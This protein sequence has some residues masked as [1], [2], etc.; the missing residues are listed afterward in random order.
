MTPNHR[1]SHSHRDRY[2]RTLAEAFGPYA[3]G[4]IHA[5]EQS[6]AH[7]WLQLG[8]GVLVAAVAALL[9]AIV[10]YSFFAHYQG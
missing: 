8:Q 1:H 2:P 4:P 6:R 9:V 10:L 7:L 5:P 3:K